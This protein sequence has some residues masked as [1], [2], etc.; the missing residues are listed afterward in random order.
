MSATDGMNWQGV[1]Q[2]SEWVDTVDSSE[3]DILNEELNEEREPELIGIRAA[4]ETPYGGDFSSFEICIAAEVYKCKNLQ[5]ALDSGLDL[6]SDTVAHCH[7]E[8]IKRGMT[9]DQVRKAYKSGDMEVGGWRRAMKAVVFG[10]FYF[11]GA[12]KASESLNISLPEAEEVLENFF[13]RF[14]EIR[15]YRQDVERRFITADTAR[16]FKDSV[17]K[18]DDSVTDLTGWKRSWAFEK[19]VATILWELGKE[20][21]KT[22]KTGTVIR[23]VEKGGQAINDAVCS[24][25]LGSAIAIQAA[26]SRQAGNMPV[27]GTGANLCTE[28]MAKIWTECKIPMLNIHDELI[29]SQH[30]NFQVAKIEE[31]IKEWETKRRSLVKSLKFESKPTK[32]W[33]DK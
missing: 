28:L 14:P 24:A 26:C 27:Q 33:S 6:H 5:D 20:K 30:P 32:F 31:V 12:Q 15:T 4:L 7:L 2:A 11:M 29:V 18:M 3:D 8:A 19:S 16:W 1:C 25:L 17:S 21:P 13:N 22:G 23:T 9:Y 10:T